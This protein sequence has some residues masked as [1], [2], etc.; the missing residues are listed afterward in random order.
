MKE[1]GHLINIQMTTQ[2][3]RWIF[4]FS[5]PGSSL[6][7]AILS[8]GSLTGCVALSEHRAQEAQY[9]ARVRK[10]ELLVR[11]RDSRI[12]DLK[13]KNLVLTRRLANDSIEKE[14]TK[15]PPIPFAENEGS[16]EGLISPELEESARLASKIISS[17]PTEEP[18]MTQLPTAGEEQNQTGE[19]FLYSKVL[20]S[21]REKEPA[22]LRQATEFLLKT[23]PD[24]SF[25]DNS[26]YLCGL[27]AF[28][29]GRYEIAIQD[30]EK[31]LTRFPN[32]NKAVTALLSKAVA[33]K[34]MGQVQ[35]SRQILLDIKKTYPGSP[36]AMWAKLELTQLSPKAR[37]Q[38]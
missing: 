30:F 8:F 17:T 37:S 34:K 21:Y 1:L 38:Q 5:F 16:S 32:G 23:Y 33:L 12:A 4:Q 9:A 25:A 18:A 36:E 24:S 35:K 7:L 15:K 29:S 22:E 3:R 20:S 19:H 26:L 27:Q 31:V 28:E 13:E 14:A 2:M 10:L 11:Q 6:M